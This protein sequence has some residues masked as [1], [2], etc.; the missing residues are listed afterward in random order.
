MAGFIALSIFLSKLQSCHGMVCMAAR[1]DAVF[2]ALSY[3]V[4]IASA[5][6]LGIEISKFERKLQQGLRSAYHNWRQPVL[7]ASRFIR[8]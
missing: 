8:D 7:R 3:V 6:I 1:A 2:A 4:W 5:T